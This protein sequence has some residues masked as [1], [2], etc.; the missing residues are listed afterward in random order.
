MTRVMDEQD[1]PLPQSVI[2][3]AGVLKDSTVISAFN[4]LGVASALLVDV[5]VAAK[6][7]LGA[8][9][10][11]LFIAL[12]IP[13]LLA[14]VLGSAIRPVLVP[15]FA[16]T[17]V[18]GGEEE[19]WKLF[20][21]LI[22][23]SIILLA[24]VALVGIVCSPLLMFV[25]A[26]GL[27]DA[28]RQVAISLNRVLFAMV[29]MAGLAEI[30][31]AMLNSYRRFAVPAAAVFVQFSV[32]VLGVLLLGGRL[33]I[34]AVAIGYVLGSVV[35]LLVLTATLLV[36]GGRYYPVLNIRDPTVRQVGRLLAPL[37]LGEVMGQGSVWVERFLA[38]FLPAGSV[39][40]LVYAR[41]VLRALT[42]AFVNSVSN[43]LLP[44]LSVL[45]RQGDLKELRS[46]ILFGIKLTWGICAPVAIGVMAASTP[47]IGLLFQRGAF[48]E[49]AVS[50]AATILMLYMPGLPFMALLQLTVSPH[51]A[52]KDT[53]TPLGIRT[54]ALTLLVVLQFVLARAIGVYGLAA[55]LSLDRVAAAVGAHI[56]LRRKIGAFAEDLWRYGVKVAA[57]AI[58]MGL[59]VLPVISW[60]EAQVWISTPL[61]RILQLGSAGLLGLA[62]YVTSLVLLRVEEV[63]LGI[64]LVKTKLIG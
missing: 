2:G 31:K 60:T 11:A 56:I 34:Q 37:F 35:Q 32:V 33:G 59:V 62:A 58:I 13:Q 3:V 54:A 51:Y 50:I 52:F 40:A 24:I 23:L 63:G 47:L 64:A 36:L 46:S 41:R 26:P 20:S 28:P 42:L 39:S 29:M 38:S 9:T 8:N 55:A 44:R 5:V 19:N 10:D 25:S 57:A 27:K 22:N 48:D 12:T 45:V 16:T 53:K 18:E 14:S 15:L 61:R 49:R 30:M 4:V 6:Y 17:R 1:E 21:N 7:G 43:A